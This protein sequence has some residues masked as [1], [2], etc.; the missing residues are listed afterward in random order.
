MLK[1]ILTVLLLNLRFSNC[2]YSQTYQNS[3][4]YYE[5]Y[6]LDSPYNLCRD[7]LMR[8][9]RV[10]GTSEAH[11]RGADLAILWGGS[12]WTAENSDFDQV[13]LLT[14]LRF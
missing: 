14:D 3:D 4:S 1:K 13:K 6:M 12:G 2:Q 10:T 7:P 5:R 11:L 8:R 9:S